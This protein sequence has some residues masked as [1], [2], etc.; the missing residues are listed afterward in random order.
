[1]T[2]RLVLLDAASLA[3]DTAVDVVMR[4]RDP[5]TENA[6]GARWHDEAR[7]LQALTHRTRPSRTP[8]L[9]RSR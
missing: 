2:P 6:S 8:T 4:S 5:R 7:S 9:V 3:V 1:M